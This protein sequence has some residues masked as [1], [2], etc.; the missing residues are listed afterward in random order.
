[1]NK[2]TIAKEACYHFVKIMVDMPFNISISMLATCIETYAEHE[3]YDVYSIL[4]ALG[5]AYE[6][7]REGGGTNGQNDSSNSV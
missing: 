3:G 6:K 4:M 1:M 2:E 5:D 7:R